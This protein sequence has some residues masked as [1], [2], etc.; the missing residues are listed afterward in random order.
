[1]TP[2]DID[3][4]VVGCGPVGMSLAVLLAQRGHSVTILE[5]WPQAY[6]LPRAVHLDHEVA[7]IFQSAGIGAELADITEPADVYEWRNGQ[8]RTLLRL[9]RVGAGTS[10]WP[11]SLMFHQ[12]TLEA[13]LERRARSLGVDIRRGCEVTD[14]SE[15]E[16]AVTVATSEGDVLE[17]RYAVG[18][19]GANST[20]RTL[21]DVAM[22]EL[23]FFYDW[24][25]VDVVLHDDRVFDPTNVQICDPARPTTVV[26]GGPGRRRWEFMRLD[27]ER[28]DELESRTWELLEPWDVGADN[29]T[30][31]RRAVYTFAARFAERWRCGRVLL[32][33]DAAHQMPPF[34]GQGMC[35]GIRDAA[36]L[37]WK[38]DLVLTGAAADALL[39]TYEQERLPSVRRAIEFSIELGKVIYVSDPNAASARDQAMAPLVGSEPV[40][41]PPLPGIECGVLAAGI[42]H[43]GSLFV[44]GTTGGRRVDDRP[45]RRLAPRHH[46]RRTARA[47]TGDEPLVRLHR[48]PRGDRARRRSG[49]WPLVHRTRRHR[50]TATTRLPPL[51]H[52][53]LR[54]R[55]GRARGTPAKPAGKTAD[56]RRSPPLKLANIDGRAALVLGDE[57]ADVATASDGRFGPD[58]MGLYDEWDAF[59]D[60]AAT[61][62]TGT[63]PL[64]DAELRNPVP[65][66][67]Q[68]FAI[69]LNYRSHAEESGMTPPEVPAVFTK[70][71]ASL[72]GPFDDISVAGGSVDWEVELVVVV[73]RT[74]DRVAEPDAW[75]HVAGVTIGQ[76]ISDRHLQFAAGA[77]FSL[78][79]SRRGYGP[80]GPWVVTPDEL[81]NPDDLA[82]G[83]SVNG[84]KMQDA[85]TAD[86]IFNVPR[87]IAELSAVLPVLPGDIIFTG[88]PAGVG[89]A[90]QPPRFLQ[91]G[92]TLETWIEGVGTIRNRIVAGN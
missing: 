40:A 32:A 51:R 5:R 82:L 34:A 59:R 64:V 18:C 54:R 4:I 48:R 27:H 89:I 83:C 36:N 13:V 42:P 10:G 79:K 55:R 19:D 49:H 7:R 47:R 58:L 65:R 33:G 11:L 6:P 92:D 91:P 71:P 85:R 84:E 80:V 44:Q 37:A 23:G 69:G 29:A 43:A 88:T 39:D 28:L 25:I 8:G 22:T 17:S 30:V 38:L 81:T 72:A 16:H 12:P 77:Q 50:R 63:G 70:F 78:G 20:V 62:T 87:L 90:R 1:M 46:R 3:V 57:I 76:D 45:R 61:V 68:V 86:L 26:S 75:T 15:H 41:A 66:P 31:E 52:R 53:R 74:A 35:A 9:G 56:T 60:L 14:V 24:L 21:L 67:R 73:G 2:T